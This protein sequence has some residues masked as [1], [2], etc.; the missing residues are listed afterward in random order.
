MTNE[1]SKEIGI[2]FDS[3]FKQFS[4]STT[5]EDSNMNLLDLTSIILILKKVCERRVTS[6]VSQKV[7]SEGFK[8]LEMVNVKLVRFA[9]KVSVIMI[10]VS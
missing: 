8:I 2:R 4:L 7:S 9:G 1:C 5:E 10:S 6:S 3:N